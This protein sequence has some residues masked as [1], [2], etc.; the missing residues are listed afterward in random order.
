MSKWIRR[1]HKYEITDTMHTT[2][3]LTS[4]QLSLAFSPAHL[5]LSHALFK[6]IYRGEKKRLELSR[7]V[8]SSTL[9]FS[10]SSHR[11]S[12]ITHIFSSRFLDS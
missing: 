11:L 8:D 10:L 1:N 6:E 4:P 2:C 12:F 5:P 7:H 9:A 3:L